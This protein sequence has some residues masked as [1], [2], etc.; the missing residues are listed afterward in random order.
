[1]WINKNLLHQVGDQT[2]VMV[3]VCFINLATCF[4]LYFRSSAGH[5]IYVIMLDET[6][7]CK[8]R[9]QIHEIKIQRDFV[10]F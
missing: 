2:K 8:S 3:V 1:M 7:L 10:E 6:I 5:K 9:I 4:S